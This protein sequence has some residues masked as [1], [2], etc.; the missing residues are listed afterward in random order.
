MQTLR[1]A[2]TLA[3][4]VLLWFALSLGAAVAAPL[5]Q[6]QALQLVCSAPG[7]VKL[8]AASAEGQ[9]TDPS[10]PA[11]HCPLCAAVGALPPLAM[12]QFGAAVPQ[13]HAPVPRDT[14]LH[15]TP[16]CATPPPARAPPARA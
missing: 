2:H 10:S 14:G 5:I 15:P 1:N 7:N 11:L 4:L 8:V 12:V 13:A 9:A 3:R 16:A 6:P